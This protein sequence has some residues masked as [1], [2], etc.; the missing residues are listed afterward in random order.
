M[1]LKTVPT[2]ERDQDRGWRPARSSVRLRQRR[3]STSDWPR[4]LRRDW[5]EE[6]AEW[7]KSE[8]SASARVV[9]LQNPSEKRRNGWDRLERALSSDAWLT[10]ISWSMERSAQF[11]PSH[12]CSQQ[13]QDGGGI[14]E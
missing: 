14:S 1:P 6:R 2:P 8:A 11:S 3:T 7:R 13:L 9:P 5:Q 12:G 4:G 10:E